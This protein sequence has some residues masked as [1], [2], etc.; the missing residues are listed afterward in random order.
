M[1]DS[2]PF[3]R[4]KTPDG[5]DVAV[6]DLGGAGEALVMAH[7]TG[8]HA[9]V[10]GELARHLSSFH[11]YGLDLR[12]HGC[13]HAA[14][15]W[16]GQWTG[17]ASDLLS[18]LDG[19]GLQQP[20]AFGHSCGGAALLLAEE[21]A[22]GTFRHLYCYEPIVAPVV[23]PLPA[24]FDNPMSVAAARRRERFASKTDAL[25]NYAS[26]PPLSILHPSVLRAYVEHGFEAEPDGSVRLRCR[27]ADEARV[28]ANAVGH[29]AFAKLP[30]VRCPVDLA[31]GHLTDSFG[32]DVQVALDE[33]MA[34]AGGACRLTVFD[35]L[36]HFGPMER[37]ALVAASMVAAFSSPPSTKEATAPPL[38]A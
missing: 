4:F 8:F 32:K 20:Y 27:P 38:P 14:E 1:P 22:P 5:S 19:L 13:S 23:D 35:E 6:H 15:S 34:S 7:A 17:F 9:M 3:A 21:A 33:R 10:L 26:K 11:C 36:G 12:A 25:A 29:D 28:F 2:A 16:N 18:V 31:C 30:T 24:N 37:P